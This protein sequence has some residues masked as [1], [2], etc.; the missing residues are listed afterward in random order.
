M[1]VIDNHKINDN[2][3]DDDDDDRELRLF[4]AFTC[5]VILFLFVCLHAIAIQF[6]PM[7][8]NEIISLNLSFIA[9]SIL[10]YIF[11]FHHQ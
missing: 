8:D 9:Q 11:V 7:N 5:F 1:K 4:V 6:N 3:D 2:D 10:F